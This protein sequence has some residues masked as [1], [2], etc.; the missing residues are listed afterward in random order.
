MERKSNYYN[1]GLDPYEEYFRKKKKG[2]DED[3]YFPPEESEP[4]HNWVQRSLL[5]VDLKLE[6]ATLFYKS[7]DNIGE[8]EA[9]LRSSNKFQRMG[10]GKKKES[11]FT[12]STAKRFWRNWEN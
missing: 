3:T 1:D 9:L 7:M 10:E 6:K 2:N 12:R 11:P 8:N 5:T 4:P